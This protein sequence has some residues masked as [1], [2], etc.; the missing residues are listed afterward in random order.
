MKNNV[1]R[2]W[3]NKKFLVL[4]F[5]LPVVL[6]LSAGLI[7]QAEQHAYRVG[8]IGDQENFKDLSGVEAEE[9]DAF[10]ISSDLAM[11]VYQFV[12][13]E[14][15]EGVRVVSNLPKYEQEKLESAL[16]N[17]ELSLSEMKAGNT[18]K[19]ERGAAF[20]A[21]TL[22]IL[23]TVSMS[24]LIHDRG[25]GLYQRFC[26]VTYK[27]GAYHLGYI[28]YVMILTYLQAFAGCFVLKLINPDES[29]MAWIF[30]LPLFISAITTIISYILC[31]TS[32]SEVQANISSSAIS[33]V[34]ALLGGSFVAV[35]KMPLLLQHISVISP[36]YWAMQIVARF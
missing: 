22:M 5:L 20:L 24:K 31:A 13:I 1:K 19:T 25:A 11:G 23:T 30:L 27:K 7:N 12:L 21:M 8:I 29:G 36:M 33:I 15:G 6:C 2:A 28:L 14:T 16:A 34:L 3:H 10:H 32:Q 4:L 17:N 35:E 26:M 9:T 18:T